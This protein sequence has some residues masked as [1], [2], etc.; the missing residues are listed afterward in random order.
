MRADTKVG[1]D[2]TMKERDVEGA[3][4]EVKEGHPILRTLTL[5]IAAIALTAANAQALDD[6]DTRGDRIERRLDERGDRIDRR[7][8]RRGERLGKRR[9][10]RGGRRAEH[11]ERRHERRA[12]CRWR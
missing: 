3:K 12:E 4:A 10:E 6:L 2:M 1:E 9:G 5:A 8:D 7:L 11:R